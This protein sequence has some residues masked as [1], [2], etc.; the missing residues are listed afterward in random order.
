MS[1]Q[2]SSGR[3]IST[4]LR[5]ALVAAALLCAACAPSVWAALEPG[6]SARFTRPSGPP[7]A[8]APAPDGRVVGAGNS[9]GH[10]IVERVTSAGAAQAAY[11]AGVGTARAI[12]VQADGKIVVAGD[13]AVSMLV[14]RLNADGSTDTGFGVAG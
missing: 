3:R 4:R 13:D 9:G 10:M 12:A 5:A 6:G 7:A 1:R 14:R 11:D 8:L 2:G